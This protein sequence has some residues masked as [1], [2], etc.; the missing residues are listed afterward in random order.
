MRVARE[1]RMAAAAVTVAALGACG[2]GGGDDGGVDPGNRVFTTFTVSP[3]E[4]TVLVGAT[5]RL[6][7]I[8]RDQSSATMSG[9]SVSYASSDQAIATVTSAGVVTGVAPGTARIT[10]TGTVGSV[11]KTATADITV[12][13]TAPQSASVTA[14]AASTFDPSQVTVARNGTV[15]WT[16]A[17]EHNVTFDGSGAPA[18]IGNTAGGTASRVFPNSGTFS[19]H[20]TIHPGM[21]GSV[22]VP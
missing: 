14:S 13:N 21:A 15:T 11:T 8:A 9:L 12:T 19:Y 4:A 3:T 2:G 16:F 20:C 7:A 17:I 10:A 18:N 22:V 5:Q 1:W 6:T